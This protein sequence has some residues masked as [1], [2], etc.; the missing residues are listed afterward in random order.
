MLRQRLKKITIDGHQ[1]PFHH[2]HTDPYPYLGVLLSMTLNWT[3]QRNKVHEAFLAKGEK[4]LKSFASST[5][6][7]Q[8]VKN[9]I[10]RL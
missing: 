8:F 5:Q 10:S 1:I 3:F 9:S 6:K 7:M 4:I 2:P